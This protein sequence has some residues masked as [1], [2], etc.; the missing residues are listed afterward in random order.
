MEL[1][2]YDRAV[3]QGLKALELDPEFWLTHQFLAGAYWEKRCYKEAIASWETA[4]RLR[5]GYDHWPLSRLVEAYWIA[6]RRAE[7]LTALARLEELSKTAHVEPVVLAHGYGAVG[8]RND[9][10]ALLERAWQ[11]GVLPR[12]PRFRA[13]A[14]FL[15]DEPRFQDLL[16]RQGV[17]ASAVRTQPAT[18]SR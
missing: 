16:R 5:G 9:A 14:R 6:G 12:G 3:E 17:H 18:T 15:G 10:V 1:R 11:E 8:R 4:L 7:A 2:E 13:L